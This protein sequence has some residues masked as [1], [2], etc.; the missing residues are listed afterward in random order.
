MWFGE[1][2]HSTIRLAESDPWRYV[3]VLGV[4]VVVVLVLGKLVIYSLIQAGGVQEPLGA[5]LG[6]LVAAP[7]FVVATSFLLA[8]ALQI[9][10][11]H[12]GAFFLP[13]AAMFCAL[14]S[15]AVD[16]LLVWPPPWV[17]LEFVDLIRSDLLVVL[18]LS[19]FSVMLLRL[20]TVR[21]AGLLLVHFAF[22]GSTVSAVS[23]LLWYLDTGTLVPAGGSRHVWEAMMGGDGAA[24][25]PAGRNLLLSVALG[26]LLSALPL[27]I[28]NR[29]SHAR[30]DLHR[31]TEGWRLKRGFVLAIVFAVA[32]AATPSRRVDGPAAGLRASAPLVF[33]GV[34][35]RQGEER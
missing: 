23:S 5:Q 28:A 19:M 16:R 21:G 6:D 12:A 3:S 31:A 7:V 24:L 14:G 29:R 22:A 4:P 20:G 9:R 8:A 13:A 27:F 34:A 35:G 17:S 30:L 2:A 11:A 26:L 1:M 33:I 25:S 18:T 15:I 10:F 32:L